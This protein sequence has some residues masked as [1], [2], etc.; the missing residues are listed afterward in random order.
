MVQVNLSGPGYRETPETQDVTALEEARRDYEKAM[1][2]INAGSQIIGGVGKYA[3]GQVK[4]GLQKAQTALTATDFMDPQR[5]SDIVRQGAENYSDTPMTDKL[6]L[7]PGAIKEFS[8]NYDKISAEQDWFT[9]QQMAKDR[10]GVL[11]AYEANLRLGTLENLDYLLANESPSREGG[12]VVASARDIRR[13]DSIGD[14]RMREARKEFL[15]GHHGKSV[16]GEMDIATLASPHYFY[17]SLEGLPDKARAVAA[18]TRTTALKSAIAS[19]RHLTYALDGALT[20]EVRVPLIREFARDIR[21]TGMLTHAQ[22]AELKTAERS[23]L[24]IGNL[25]VQL[26]T[27]KTA[28]FAGSQSIDPKNLELITGQLLREQI[29]KY[30]EIDPKST[31]E[32]GQ[33]AMDD[34]S[35]ELIELVERLQSASYNNDGLTMIRLSLEDRVMI[36]SHMDFLGSSVVSMIVGNAISI[37]EDGK[38]TSLTPKLEAGKA[39]LHGAIDKAFSDYVAANLGGTYPAGIELLTLQ[40]ILIAHTTG[41]QGDREIIEAITTGL[42]L[43]KA[44]GHIPVSV[45]KELADIIF[46]R[47]MIFDP[48]GLN[49]HAMKWAIKEVEAQF[50]TKGTDVPTIRLYGGSL[51]EVVGPWKEGHMVKWKGAFMYQ[52]KVDDDQSPDHGKL[53]LETIV[54]P[55]GEY[56]ERVE[57]PV[58]PVQIQGTPGE[59]AE[60]PPT[61]TGT[62]TDPGTDPTKPPPTIDELIDEMIG[63]GFAAAPINQRDG[64]IPGEQVPPLIDQGSNLEQVVEK[65][66]EYISEGVTKEVR[67]QAGVDVDGEKDGPGVGRA[68]YIGGTAIASLTY[69]ANKALGRYK[70]RIL[71]QPIHGPLQHGRFSSTSL[72]EVLNRALGRAGATRGSWMWT[73]NPANPFGTAVARTTAEVGTAALERVW[74]KPG[75]PGWIK[76]MNKNGSSPAMRALAQKYLMQQNLYHQEHFARKA[77]EALAG[78]TFNTPAAARSW[79]SQH[80]KL[81]AKDIVRTILGGAAK[82][83]G[84]LIGGTGRIAWGY[85]SYPWHR[86]MGQYTLPMMKGIGRAAPLVRRY[87]GRFVGRVVGAA[88]SGPASLLYLGWGIGDALQE[89]QG[90]VEEQRRAARRANMRGP[91][92]PYVDLVN[93]LEDVGYLDIPGQTELDI[94][95]GEEPEWWGTLPRRAAGEIWKR[96][97]H[98]NFRSFGDNNIDRRNHLDDFYELTNTNRSGV[99]VDRLAMDT[100]G[101]DP[102]PANERA[103]YLHGL[104]SEAL[105]TPVEEL[106]G[107]DPSVSVILGDD[108]LYGEADLFAKLEVEAALGDTH[109]KY[110]LREINNRSGVSGRSM[111]AAVVTEENINNIINRAMY[112]PPEEIFTEDGILALDLAR[113]NGVL[114]QTLMLSKGQGGHAGTLSPTGETAESQEFEDLYQ[115]VF[116][117]TQNPELAEVV[118]YHT[119]FRSRDTNGEIDPYLK[120]SEEALK[121]ID[122]WMKFSGHTI[123]LETGEYGQDITMHPDFSRFVVWRATR[124]WKRTAEFGDQRVQSSRWPNPRRRDWLEEN[125]KFHGVGRN[126]SLDDVSEEWRIFTGEDGPLYQLHEHSKRGMPWMGDPEFDPVQW[127]AEAM[128]VGDWLRRNGRAEEAALIRYGQRLDPPGRLAY[129]QLPARLEADRGAIVR[130]LR[131]EMSLLSEEDISE[132]L[133]I[134]DELRKDTLMWGDPVWGLWTGSDPVYRRTSGKHA[135]PSDDPY[136]ISTGEDSVKSRLVGYIKSR[137]EIREAVGKIDSMDDAAVAAEMTEGLLEDM[138]ETAFA[139]ENITNDSTY[140]GMGDPAKRILRTP[141]HMGEFYEGPKNVLKLLREDARTLER[142]LQLLDR[143]VAGYKSL[144]TPRP[145][146]AYPP[147]PSTTLPASGSTDRPWEHIRTPR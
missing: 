25:R 107:F 141:T 2:T 67:D 72:G 145:L 66:N 1:Q 68:V 137:S 115:R 77:L 131:P 52:Y 10:A 42:K 13:A 64:L 144:S 128:L 37:G 3:E 57:P 118:V 74:I 121:G 79:F 49:P 80:L 71:S 96:G 122:T 23:A 143:Q 44:T 127:E 86:W 50:A 104:F 88:F 146:G 95:R 55:Q 113:Y 63:G 32:A 140:F 138:Y 33:D 117:R 129:K 28:E 60:A 85:A 70:N 29:A 120:S 142:T 65:I 6:E 46:H 114:G 78:K 139:L 21:E 126:Q 54:R 110:L 99:K 91:T 112:V 14:L 61:A 102:G 38:Q 101:Y 92:P 34:L 31:P 20:G 133:Y 62:A 41:D 132:A 134:P 75:S 89:S 83:A 84:T 97:E 87:A 100:L 98:F 59:R 106:M 53:V 93:R 90:E 45:A 18:T 123:N 27:G 24:Q 103:A 7:D 5:Q 40:E 30:R 124:Q 26:L 82:G 11:A 36:L 8:E 39:E 56:L 9:R 105:G 135:D 4:K 73:A 108:M 109:A 16:V 17:M 116:D 15:Y 22:S 19:N 51:V 147:Y 94:A 69:I 43:T 125:M 119:Y 47:R 136:G 58:P 48:T 76:Y 35:G 81:G 130:Q 12:A 111:Q